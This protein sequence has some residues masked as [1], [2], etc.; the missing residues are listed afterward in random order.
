M[1]EIRRAAWQEAAAQRL[2]PRDVDLLLADAAGRELVWLLA[3]DDEALS[4]AEASHF[5]QSFDRRLQGEPLQYIRGRA[6][7]FSREFLIDSRV[8]IPRPETEHLVETVLRLAPPGIRLLDVGTGSGCVAVTAA[9]ERPDLRVVASDRSLAALAVARLNRDRSGAD[10]DLV[11][12]SLFDGIH[13]RFGAIVSNPPYIPSG[14]LPGLQREVREHEPREALTPGGDG[15]AI[16]RRLITESPAFLIDDGFVALE[17]G[18]GQSAEVRSLARDRGWPRVEIIDDL[19][20]I[21]RVAVLFRTP[22]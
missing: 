16:I 12:A 20:A 19:A 4:P 8:L 7:F 11:A 17:I 3:H 13:E 21:P 14:D 2:N 22:Q 1:R 9:L 15:L 18:F 10:V 6:E 5:R